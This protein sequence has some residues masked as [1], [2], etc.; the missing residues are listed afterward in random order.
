MMIKR[1][2]GEKENLYR[3]V[4]KHFGK[5]AQ[6]LRVLEELGELTQ[7]VARFAHTGVIDDNLIEEMAD[8]QIML[9]Q[10][11]DMTASHGSTAC[12]I[13]HK[14]SRLAKLTGYKSMSEFEEDFSG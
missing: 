11:I 7:A 6:L 12:E 4:L 5:Q 14:L 10:L 9:D 8:V 2:R 13:H 3:H 1:A